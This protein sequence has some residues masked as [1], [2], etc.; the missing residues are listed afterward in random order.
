MTLW[1]EPERRAWG[2]KEYGGPA[3]MAEALIVLPD[4]T[5]EPGP[6]RLDRTPFILEPLNDVADLG[7]REITIIAGSQL[8]KTTLEI[9]V[10]C[11]IIHEHPAECLFLMG[12][13]EDAES[14]ARDRT[15]PILKASPELAALVTS[16]GR[17]VTQKRIAINGAKIYFDTAGSAAAVSS[18]P[19][20]IVCADELHLHPDNLNGEGSPYD[21]AKKRVSNYANSKLIGT[22][23]PTHPHMIGW[24]LFLAGTQHV[25]HYQCPLCGA[26]HDYQFSQ[27]KVPEGERDSQRIR[28]MRLAW[29]ECQSCHGKIT[30]SQKDAMMR[31]GKYIA[32]NQQTENPSHKSYHISGIASPWRTF[33]Q[34]IAEFFE[35]KDN[36]AKLQSFNN[37]TLGINWED[38]VGAISMSSDNTGFGP[39]GFVPKDAQLMTCGVDWHGQRKGYYWSMWAWGW[40]DN[41]RCGWLVDHGQVYD[42]LDIAGVTWAREWS[43]VDG[44][45]WKLPILTGADSGWN[46]SEVYQFCAPHYPQV[47]PT[48]GAETVAGSTIRESTIDT[49]KHKCSGGMRLLSIHTNYYK[50]MIASNVCPGG[51]WEFCNDVDP[52]FKKHLQNE[53]K[54]RDG[55]KLTW[56]PKYVGAP[57]H[58]LDTCVIAA[59]IAD[60][61]GLDRLRAGAGAEKKKRKPSGGDAFL[62]GGSGFLKGGK[63]WLK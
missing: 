15:E 20:E 61:A 62:R 1:S 28:D 16:W 31:G 49:T 9:I 35:S 44:V 55:K 7:V 32:Q 51:A 58:Y 56:Q 25:W 47:R 52:V 53:H 8:C 39:R 36:P 46:A 40:L 54:I 37:T 29:Y 5:P 13:D 18:K 59:A 2:V 33:S 19:I 63:G 12:R 26:F 17:Q 10:E 60:W 43:T 48:K 23:T 27:I 14:I 30:E 21:L 24:V 50:D 3:E 22:S 41:V 45:V 34:I 11:W 57:N 4:T 6:I 38:R 42:P